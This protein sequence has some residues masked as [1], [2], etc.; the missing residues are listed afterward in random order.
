[1][2]LLKKSVPV[3]EGGMIWYEL[4]EMFCGNFMIKV[5]M[6]KLQENWLSLERTA[7]DDVHFLIF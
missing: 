5:N 4:Q 2:R 7:F 6:P 1:M 3:F